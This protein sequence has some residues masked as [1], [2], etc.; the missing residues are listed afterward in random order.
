MENS[1]RDFQ[2]SIFDERVGY[3]PERAKENFSLLFVGTKGIGKISFRPLRKRL[4]K[5]YLAS[6]FVEMK[7]IGK[8]PFLFVQEEAGI[9]ETIEY[10]KR[11]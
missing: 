8:N 11:T 10:G 3:L 9:I 6:L 7:D 2:F 4:V 5:E 1:S